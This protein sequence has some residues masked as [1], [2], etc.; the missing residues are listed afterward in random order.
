MLDLLWRL[1]LRIAIHVL[2]GVWFFT[3][4][5]AQGA[6][7]A[8][9]WDDRL[10]LIRNSYRPGEVI[11][12]GAIKRGETPAHAA[13]RELREEVGIDSAE[14]DLQFV[15]EICIPFEHKRDHSHFFELHLESEPSM[16]VDNREVVWAGFV[17]RRELTTRPLVPHVQRYLTAR[18]QS[19]DRAAARDD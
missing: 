2:R 7:V 19:D 8:V 17:P 12:C 11:P 9:W 5:D 14:S 4:P 1:G 10:L 16:R 13:A 15:C 18:E 6:Y 3:R